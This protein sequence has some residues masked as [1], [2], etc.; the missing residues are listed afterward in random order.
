MDHELDLE[1]EFAGPKDKGAEAGQK[2]K[3][4][5]IAKDLVNPN[6]SGQFEKK[7]VELGAMGDTLHTSAPVKNDIGSGLVEYETGYNMH[8]APLRSTLRSMGRLKDMQSA[9][10]PMDPAELKSD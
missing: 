4:G 7:G 6:A 8:T 1:Q 10:A 3:E 5:R 9:G 2:K